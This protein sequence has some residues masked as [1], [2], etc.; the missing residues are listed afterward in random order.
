MTEFIRHSHEPFMQVFLR[1]S[2]PYIT[3]LC[4]YDM[5]HL[6]PPSKRIAALAFKY[7][8]YR[9]P[10]PFLLPYFITDFPIS[11]P[12]PIIYPSCIDPC[13]PFLLTSPSFFL[14]YVG[15]ENVCVIGGDATQVLPQRIP[16]SSLDY[17][18]INH[19]EPPQQTG[20]LDSQ[21]KH[22]ITMVSERLR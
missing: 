2:Q 19:P 14:F 13:H 8:V 9:L 21:G 6:S 7:Q 11:F 4:T 17:L 3:R 12:V 16:S 10:S 20:G 15:A 5:S 22:L 18:F 1:F